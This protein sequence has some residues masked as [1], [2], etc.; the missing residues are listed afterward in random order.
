MSEN[1]DGINPNPKP[2]EDDIKSI[3]RIVTDYYCFHVPDLMRNGHDQDFWVE[4]QVQDFY[5]LLV[6][7]RQ[8][9]EKARSAR[10]E[11][12][13]K[14]R[15]HV[16]SH[17]D[18]LDLLE[19]E[20]LNRIEQE[21]KALEERVTELTQSNFKLKGDIEDLYVGRREVREELARLKEEIKCWETDSGL[22][23]ALRENEEIARLTSALA[24]AQESLR[25]IYEMPFSSGCGD[26][27]RI[28]QEALS[29]PSGSLAF[30]RWKKM[31]AVVEVAKAVMSWWDLNPEGTPM[32]KFREALESL[33]AKGASDV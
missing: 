15:P 28:A 23:K 12:L 14:V 6:A 20:I 33:D 17:D 5:L 7:Q 11:G 18:H 8:A 1:P 30:E 26:E 3:R 29:D 9:W 27:Q 31:E 21:K 4:K 22:T 24:A 2:T 13:K 25:K 32:V 19:A 10:V 16:M